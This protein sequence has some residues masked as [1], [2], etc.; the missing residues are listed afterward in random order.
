MKRKYLVWL[1]LTV[2]LLILANY[3]WNAISLRFF[4]HDK[5]APLT[6][7]L[8]AEYFFTELL[9]LVI[10]I[11]C[12]YSAYRL[13]GP[14]LLFKNKWY[15]AIIY[16]VLTIAA[17]SAWRYFAEYRVLLPYLGFDNYGGHPWAASDYI[18]NVF[19]YYF[20]SYFVYGLMYF[21]VEGW[22]KTRLNQQELLKEKA[23]AELAFLRSQLNPHFLFNSINDIYSLTW[24]KS[25]QAPAALLKLSEIL[26][27]MLREDTDGLTPLSKEVNYI[28]NVIDL[29]RISAKGSA[30][31]NFSA[32]GLIDGQKV[33]SLIFIPFVEN[34][35]KHG[36]LND[37]DH[38]VQISLSATPE[39]IHFSAFNQ[40]N[41]HQKDITGGIGLNNIKR[42]LE[43]LYPGSHELRIDDKDD[44]YH[45]NLM[46]QL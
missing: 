15:R 7:V 25:E 38:P 10:P 3:M 19:Y 20:P 23:A 39:G 29:Q 43:L 14:A 28:E 4:M 33:P 42:R 16:T 22:Y 31:I 41:D 26:R 37:A 24:Q 35:F 46:L 18:S 1:H 36:V 40:K 11:L 13:V 5:Q 30:F 32:E 27:Y 6:V 44:S 8:F 9:Y 34:A 12:F 21:F 17:A 45:V 2:W